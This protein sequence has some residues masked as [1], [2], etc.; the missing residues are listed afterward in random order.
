MH[1]LP[2]ADQCAASVYDHV[3]DRSGQGVVQF[4]QDSRD[5][6][7]YAVKFFLHRDAFLNEAALYASCFACVRSAASPDVRARADASSC[8]G[9]PSNSGGTMSTAVARFLPQ[10]EAVCDSATAGSC[11]RDAQ[12][13]PLPPCVVMEKGESLHD[14]CDR[15]EPELFTALAVRCHSEA[16]LRAACG[17]QPAACCRR[18]GGP[19]ASQIMSLHA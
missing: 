14:L 11:V 16:V 4:V 2:I 19:V 17:R 18:A 1:A 3:N 6:C 12:G 7:D 8:A 5:R 13:W 10:V 15:A 9:D